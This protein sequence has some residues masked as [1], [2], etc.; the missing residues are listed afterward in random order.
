MFSRKEKGDVFTRPWNCSWAGG[1]R[2]GYLW[3]RGQAGF[4]P[5]VHGARVVLQEDSQ[6]TEEFTDADRLRTCKYEALCDSTCSCCVPGQHGLVEWILDWKSGGLG[7]VTSSDL[8]I[9]PGSRTSPLCACFPFLCK[10]LR[11]W[12]VSHYVSVE[13]PAQW[14]PDL[15]WGSLG[16]TVILLIGPMCGLALTTTF[17]QIRGAR[18]C[19]SSS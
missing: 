5:L 17:S 6:Q 16:A 12:A 7:S 9:C 14:D 4:D 1:W 11:T 15:T 19:W 8:L 18:L 3:L 2:L 13:C 10:V